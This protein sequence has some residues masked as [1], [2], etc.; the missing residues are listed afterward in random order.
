MRF[1]KRKP[2]STRHIECLAVLVFLILALLSF[3]SVAQNST[4]GAPLSVGLVL[5]VPIQ[6]EVDGGLSFFLQRMI[7]RAEREQ[8]RALVLEINSNG[9]LVDSAQEMKDALLR[10]KI[11]TVAYIKGRALS[12]AALIAISCHRIYMEPG[13]EMGAATP[14]KLLSTG[15]SPVE[16]KFLSAFRAEFES[17]AEAR[18]RPKALAGAMVDKNHESI[19]G[20][21]AR[22]EILTLTTEAAATHGYCDSIVDSIPAALRRM[23]IEA[24]PLEQVIPTSGEMLARWLTSPNVSVILFTAGIWALILEF[25]VFGW[26]VLGWIGLMCLGLFFGGHLFAYLAG[27]EALLLFFVGAILLLVELFVLPGFGVTGFLGI[28]ALGFSTILVFGGIYSAIQAISKF[29]ALSIVMLLSL[30][31]IAP[32][33]KL[34]DRFILKEELTTANGFVAVDNSAFDNLINLEGITLSPLRPSGFVRIGSQKFEV[35]SDGDFVER[36]QRVTVVAIEG[37]K[38]VVR[39]L[40]T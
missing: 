9:G 39:P 34:F 23:N 28:A 24:A 18:G 12:A 14:F 4:A 25:L 22:G 11:P 2:I 33:L 10:A 32:R 37:T 8:A 29:M 16:E 15:I 27:L 20:L 5:I 6:G 26:G 19:P 3:P 40:K 36:N 30:Y 17:T 35:V 1:P 13:S 7:R 21:V 31:Y 38:I